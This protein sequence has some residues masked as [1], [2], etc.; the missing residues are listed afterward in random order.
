MI[1]Y[2][3]RWQFQLILLMNGSICV[4]F[5]FET[6]Q[7]DKWNDLSKMGSGLRVNLTRLNP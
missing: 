2:D 4:M 1:I 6:D 5:L 3:S 7:I